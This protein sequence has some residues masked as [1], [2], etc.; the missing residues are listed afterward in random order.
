M[1]AIQTAVS[2]LLGLLATGGSEAAVEIF[3][4]AVIK[5]AEGISKLWRDIFAHEPESYPLAN[6]VARNPED[7]VKQQQLRQ[8]LEEALKN[9]P[10]LLQSN[11]IGTINSK[12]SANHFIDK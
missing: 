1:I 11:E 8:L 6:Q 9:H 10:E 12:Y 3:K 7:Q 2:A 5:G 4:G